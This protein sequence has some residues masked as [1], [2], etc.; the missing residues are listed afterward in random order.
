ML[1]MN[2]FDELVEQAL[3]N[4]PEL[5]SLRIVVEKE[6]LHHDI[7]RIMRDHDL[8]QKLTFIGGTCLR[9]CYNSNRLSED[10]GF[11]GGPDFS[12]KHPVDLA[13]LLIKNLQD[14]YGLRVTVGVPTK[15]KFN[16]DTWKI[17]VETRK[18]K[19]HLPAQRINIDIC[20]VP[21]YDAHPTVLINQYGVDM[22]TAGLILQAQSQE[23]IYTDKLLAFAL[24][25]NRIKYRDLWDIFWLTG[26]GI[27]PHFDL[28]AN[29]LQ[30]YNLTISHFLQAFHDRVGWL[31]QEP[32][33]QE[34]FYQEMARFLPQA[35]IRNMMH[36]HGTWQFI[37]RRMQE[38]HEQIQKNLQLK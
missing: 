13:D 38:L 28:I 8:L 19:K 25:P 12:R 16:V 36:N 15:D 26:L 23:E 37:V 21:S 33:L 4:H 7:L 3:E 14:K 5:V 32:H 29:K 31:Q 30:D 9:A 17:T 24:R 1:Q 20:S 18:H 11:T 27:K 22:G 10:L 35:Q 6:L 34:E 2:L